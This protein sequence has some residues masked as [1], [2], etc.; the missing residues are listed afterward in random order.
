MGE[1]HA[2]SC[3]VRG[4]SGSQQAA[5]ASGTSPG[6]EQS[7][8]FSLQA[9]WVQRQ[10]GFST[11]RA[12]LR[13]VSRNLFLMSRRRDASRPVHVEID[14]ADAEWERHEA[15][16]GE[17]YREALRACLEILSDR[18]RAALD[19]AALA[20]AAALLHVPEARV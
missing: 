14:A 5:S 8:P 4:T 16:D 1:V 11:T 18:A 13:T 6:S 7:T 9:H 15:D 12:Y 10:D 17:G 20:A 19:D 2:R 3:R